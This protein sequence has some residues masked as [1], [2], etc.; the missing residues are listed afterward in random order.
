MIFLVGV[1]NLEVFK[2][3]LL[4]RCFGNALLS[5]ALQAYQP[6][7]LRKRFWCIKYS[8]SFEHCDVPYI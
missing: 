4:L 1:K 5:F 6:S 7:G 2:P 8:F 3:E